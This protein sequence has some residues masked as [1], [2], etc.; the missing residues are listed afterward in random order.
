VSRV[1]ELLDELRTIHD[2]KNHDYAHSAD[3][4]ANFR[5][6]ARIGITPFQGVIVRMGDKWARICNLVR[7][8]DPAVK[9]ESLRDTLKDLAV[10]ALIAVAL[11]EEEENGKTPHCPDAPDAGPERRAPDPAGADGDVASPA[12]A[13]E[14]L[15]NSPAYQEYVKRLAEGQER[16]NRV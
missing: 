16:L 7:Y 13:Y 8:G 10:Y 11:D 2:T 14:R 4:F 1:A 12:D 5:E 15:R 9:D 6:A 3:P